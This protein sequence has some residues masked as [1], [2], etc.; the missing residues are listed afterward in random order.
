MIRNFLQ[1]L[2]T[3]VDDI[4][5]VNTIGAVAFVV[6]W[7]D[8]DHWIRTLGLVAALVYTICKIA[9]AIKDLKR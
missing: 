1:Q 3:H 9:Q 5:K 2:D 4:L 6:S 7:S 8:F